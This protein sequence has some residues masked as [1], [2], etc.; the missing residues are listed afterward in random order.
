MGLGPVTLRPA[1]GH[2]LGDGAWGDRRWGLAWVSELGWRNR[3][4]VRELASELKDEGD[5]GGRRELERKRKFIDELRAREKKNDRRLRGE[6]G[7]RAEG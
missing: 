7:R 2:E 3:S 6:G 5:E 4:A 1:E